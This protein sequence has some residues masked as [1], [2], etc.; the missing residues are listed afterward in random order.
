MAP[1]VILGK[2]YGISADYWSIGI[3]LFEFL[4]G[5]VPF[6]ENDSDNYSIYE[7]ILEGKIVYPDY[8]SPTYEAKKF[9][10]QLLNSNPALRIGGGA[11]NLKTHAWFKDY[12]WENIWDR[13]AAVPFKPRTPNFKNDL[14]KILKNV[15]EEQKYSP[16]KENALKF[17]SDPSSWDYEF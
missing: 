9:I 10:E 13:N 4:C 8:S 17:Q 11:D 6:G 16:A 14:D 15:D 2:G 12:Q 1:E 7:K 5:G 3:M